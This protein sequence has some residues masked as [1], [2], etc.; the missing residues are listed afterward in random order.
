[1]Q[2]LIGQHIE[3]TKSYELGLLIVGLAPVVGLIALLFCWPRK[4]I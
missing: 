3:A 2:I 1:M 4:S